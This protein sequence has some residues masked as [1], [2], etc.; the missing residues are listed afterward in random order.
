MR[1]IPSFIFVDSPSVKSLGPGKERVEFGSG[2]V[3]RFDV[4]RVNGGWTITSF[5]IE[6]HQ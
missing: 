6:H 1:D 3:F 4:E 2:E 5:R